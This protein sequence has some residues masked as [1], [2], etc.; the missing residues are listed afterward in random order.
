MGSVLVKRPLDCCELGLFEAECEVVWMRV[1]TSKSEVRVLNQKTVGCPCQ[2][3]ALSKV[4]ISSVEKMKCE[5]H[6]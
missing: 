3:A 5:I 6:I 2:V 4:C 1:S